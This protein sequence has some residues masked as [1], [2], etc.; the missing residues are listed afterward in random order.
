MISARHHQNPRLK[1]IYN[2]SKWCKILLTMSCPIYFVACNTNNKNDS[3]ADI[4]QA[5]ADSTFNI[6][7]ESVDQ[8]DTV[9]FNAIIHGDS[10]TGSLVYQF[11]EKDK[12]MGSILGTIK[13]DTLRGMYTFKS[14]GIES[15]REIVFLREDTLLREGYGNL[16]QKDNQ[17][18]FADVTKLKFDG[19][20]LQKVKCP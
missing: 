1:Y 13:G 15:V 16:T 8:K 10:V 5:E 11:Y 12:N 17:V 3:A 19:L 4:G 14:E 18:V 2:I 6:C 9:L 7:Y 20:V